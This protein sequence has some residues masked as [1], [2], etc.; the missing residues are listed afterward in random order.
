MSDHNDS[1]DPRTDITDLYVF[2]APGGGD[3]SVLVLCINP[4]ASASEPGFDSAASYE[5]KID[6]DSDLEAGVCFHVLF[7]SS[8]EG[9]ST[10]T[11]YRSTGEAARG[12]GP[13]GEVVVSN[14]PV[15][16]GGEV[17]IVAVDGYRF[18]AGLRSDPTFFDG[19]GMRNAFQFTGHD[20]FA[21]R[22]VFGIVDRTGQ[23][24]SLMIKP[25]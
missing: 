16:V 10:A 11:L 18:F 17:Q 25:F 8:P 7:A 1:P 24:Y 3:R 12:T 9:A 20:S 22:N 6:T 13:V 4:K 21:D 23:V 5:L 19:A 2:P 15:S 14:A